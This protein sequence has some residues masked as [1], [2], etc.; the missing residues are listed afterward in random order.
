MDKKWWYVVGFVV[1]ILVLMFMFKD[2]V[3]LGPR[4]EVGEV[5][6]E[7]GLESKF[8]G[9][10]FG[11]NGDREKEMTNLLRAVSGGGG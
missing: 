6:D 1:I 3:G 9:K 2:D 4:G 11:E 7:G 5:N 8:F 10:D